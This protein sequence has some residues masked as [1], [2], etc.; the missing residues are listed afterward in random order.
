[1]GYGIALDLGTSGFR[2][3]LIDLETGKIIA[4]AM[5]TR[6]PL[7]GANV[8]DHLNFAVDFGLD[9]AHEIVIAAVNQVVQALG[10]PV[11]EI[12]RLAVCGNPIQLSLFEEIEIR[13]MA[14]AGERKRQALGVVSPDR[15]GK[16]VNAAKIRRLSLLPYA[17]V[18]IPPSV[19]HEIG[20]DALAMMIKSGLLDCQ[21][22][23]LVT[24]YGTNAE[25]ALKV[26]DNIYT[27]SCAAGPALEGQHITNGMLAAPGAIADI[28]REDK[29]YRI[30]VINR[31][32]HTEK[33]ALVDIKKER[34]IEDI[35]ITPRGIT[36]TGV[37]AVI[38]EGINGDLIKMPHV[39]AEVGLYLSPGIR[40]GTR[41]LNEAGKAIGALRAG[42][43]T[44]AHEAGVGI[45]DIRYA[46]MAGASGTYV[47]AFKAYQIGMVPPAVEKIYQIG[48]TSLAM[49]RDLVLNPALVDELRDLAKKLRAK[50]CMFGLSQVFANAYMMELAFWCEGMPWKQY[51]SLGKMFGL[52]HM[53]LPENNPEIYRLTE[54]D[55]EDTGQYGLTVIDRVGYIYKKRMMGCRGCGRCVK[56]CPE[57]A[58][59]MTED[60]DG[61][62][63]FRQR[64]D[65]CNGTACLRCKRSCPYG[66][67][68]LPFEKTPALI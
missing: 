66:V 29:G 47:S 56:E 1:M 43:L 21:E 2:G 26:G 32:M 10:V 4:T 52:P 42:Y 61:N 48:N 18:I 65:L 58:L 19:K 7:P 57:N 30:Y 25:M 3:Q 67:F 60:K 51:W 53:P 16:I 23:T 45:E 33:G 36:G 55:I 22:V 17:E 20:A 24:D 49:A 64:A 34:I 63:I 6:H 31:H 62:F 15:D 11:E 68:V 28:N 40:F 35:G 50:H 41:D 46:Y 13:D 44:L 59:E 12:F 8:M 5:T 14:Y 39:N 37:V 27:G 9:T 38:Y 54:R